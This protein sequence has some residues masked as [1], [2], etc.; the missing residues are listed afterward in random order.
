MYRDNRIELKRLQLTGFQELIHV[1]L[2][3]VGSGIEVSVGVVRDGQER[4]GAV[5][6]VET[7][8]SETLIGGRITDSVILV[9]S[10]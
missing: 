2:R 9:L 1:K 10:F 8:A 7:G 3:V 5:V 4:A 6:K